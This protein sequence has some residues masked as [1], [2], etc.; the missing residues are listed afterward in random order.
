MLGTLPDEPAT[1]SKQ[2]L[3]QIST[4]HEAALWGTSSTRDVAVNS[5]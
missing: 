5:K 3:E 1:M 2:V 4:L